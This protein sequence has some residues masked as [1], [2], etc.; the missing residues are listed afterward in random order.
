MTDYDSVRTCCTGGSICRRCWGFISCS[1]KVL[2]VALR[3]TFGFKHVLW[4]YSGRRGIHC[5]ISDRE[6]MALTDDQRKSLMGWLEVVKGGKEMTKKVNVRHN[7]KT[8]IGGLHPALQTAVRILREDFNSLIL[9][10]QNCFGNPEGWAE[11]L[12]LLP[13]GGMKERLRDT[14]EDDPKKPSLKKWE[15]IAIE[16]HS[17]QPHEK[18]GLFKQISES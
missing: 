18:V 10:D 6:A 2:D 15:D 14:W 11:L 13:D 9:K 4:V 1:V 12:T 5:W 17:A 16:M 7:T 8:K 3:D